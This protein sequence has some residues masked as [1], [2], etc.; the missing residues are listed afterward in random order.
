MP[1]YN[2]RMAKIVRDVVACTFTVKAKSE[3]A[4]EVLALAKLETGECCF[5][6]D[7]ALDEENGNV[8]I[9]ITEGEEE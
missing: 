4:A 7:F 1:H 6:F 3:K 8:E 9:E 5:D 2:V